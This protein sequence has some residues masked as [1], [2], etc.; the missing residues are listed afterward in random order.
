M[1]SHKLTRRSVLAG[2]AAGAAATALPV[3]A[4]AQA[5]PARG[6]SG[7]IRL[8][9]GHSQP[10]GHS[11]DKAANEFIRLVSERTNGDVVIELFPNN[12]LGVDRELQMMIETGQLDFTHS[13]SATMGNFVPQMGVMDLPFVWQTPEHYLRVVDGPFGEEINGLLANTTGHRYLAWWFDG[14]RNVYTA[15]RPI[16]QMSD[17]AGLKIRSPEAKVF[18]DTF[19]ALGANPTPLAFPEIYTGLESGVVDGMEGSNGIVFSS[20]LYEVAKHRA[21]TGHIMVGFGLTVAGSRFA[22]LPADVQEVISTAAKEVQTLQRETQLAEEATLVEQ[23]V[24]AGVIETK[25]D[26]APFRE[27][28][29]KVRDEFHATHDTGVLRDMIAAAV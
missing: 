9:Y 23:M 7:P 5:A 25:P 29:A 18:V 4:Y 16:E 12:Q 6:G 1:D 2:F 13:N 28:C 14:F 15:D 8:R 21:V 26:L 19:R 24:A 3:A 22:E 20:K 17:L 27:A 10:V 11:T